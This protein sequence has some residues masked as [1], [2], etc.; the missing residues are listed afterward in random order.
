MKKT[1]FKNYSYSFDKNERKVLT[2]FCKQVLK[3]MESDNRYFAEV[4][5]FNSILEKL[6]SV[7]DEVK[8]T[9]DERTRFVLQL[10]ENT[11]YLDDQ[12]KKSWFLK[13]WLYKSLYTQYKNILSIHFEE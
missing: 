2:S 11:K 10:K 12:I 7:E 13:K 8:L 5:A 9:K 6:N 1:L 3:Q 4:K